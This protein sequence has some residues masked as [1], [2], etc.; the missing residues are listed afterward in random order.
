MHNTHQVS[1]NT[2]PSQDNVATSRQSFHCCQRRKSEAARFSDHLPRPPWI[3]FSLQPLPA[4]LALASFNRLILAAL[5]IVYVLCS[6]S[7]A[8]ILCNSNSGTF[9]GAPLSAWYPTVVSN[10]EIC[11]LYIEGGHVRMGVTYQ[12]RITSIYVSILF[13]NFRIVYVYTMPE[14]TSKISSVTR[15]IFGVA[16][17]HITDSLCDPTKIVTRCQTSLSNNRKSISQ[18]ERRLVWDIHGTWSS[19]HSNLCGVWPDLQ[20]T[21]PKTSWWG[22][23]SLLLHWEDPT[24]STDGAFLNQELDRCEGWWRVGVTPW[25]CN[26]L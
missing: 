3:A 19:I 26:S 2:I 18:L 11:M 4:A 9:W 15:S 5:I 25:P 20:C 6:R 10:F 14:V 16:N 17:R 1:D 22:G 21:R 12:P 8:T 13:M 7:L 23:S 24:W